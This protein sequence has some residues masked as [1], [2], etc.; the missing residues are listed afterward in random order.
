MKTVRARYAD[1]EGVSIHY[2]ESEGPKGLPPVLFIPGLTDAADDYCNTI[3]ELGRRVL[4]IDL[5]GRGDSDAPETGYAMADHVAD[6][7]SVVKQSATGTFHLMT[8]SRGTCYGL[9]Y[10]VDHPERILSISLGDYPAREI[11]IPSEKTNA[12]M[13]GKW[14][15]RPVAE[16]L[17]ELAFSKIVAESE[18]H[19]F[20]EQIAS[21][22]LPSLVVRSGRDSP[23]T[24]ED[25]ATYLHHLPDAT[26]V[27]FEDSPHDIFRPDRLRFFRLVRYHIAAAEASAA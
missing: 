6:I 27:R 5:R 21:L 15:G 19:V 8:F 24:D 4:V 25:W 1:N 18:G 14:R 11:I 22:N 16:R 7:A 9:G 13:A 23:V 10:A 26:F 3:L 17:S 2:L 12:F 20:W